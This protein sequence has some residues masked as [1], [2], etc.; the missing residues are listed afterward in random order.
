LEDDNKK[1]HRYPFI[2]NEILN[3]DVGKINDYFLNS[4]ADLK[5]E[6]HETSEEITKVESDNN[7][8]ENEEVEETEKT[9][10]AMTQEQEQ[11]Q[12]Q[13][14]EQEPPKE[15]VKL[16]EVEEVKQVEP[17][18]NIELLDVLLNFVDT[19]GELNYVLAGYFSKFL[20]NLINKYPHRVNKY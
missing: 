8:V 6:E 2:S 7:K 1:G 20:N 4:E 18:H 14:K 3:C 9:D 10:E 15:D 12:E 11:E 16:E 5:K 19:D 13:E 17:S